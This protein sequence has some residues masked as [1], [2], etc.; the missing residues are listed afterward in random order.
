MPSVESLT[1]ESDFSQFLSEGVSDVLRRA[2]LRKLFQLP[3]F[4]ILD[5][6]N[7]YDE[8]YTKFEKLG[9]VVTYHQRQM[10]AREEA[11]AKEKAREAAEQAD[12]DESALSSNEPE[13]EVPKDQQAVESRDDA[14]ETNGEEIDD[15]GDLDA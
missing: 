4:N 12:E 13:G 14:A 8:D 11:I 6:L 1:A 15:D 3:E 9:E 5:G 10:K 2:A 7:D